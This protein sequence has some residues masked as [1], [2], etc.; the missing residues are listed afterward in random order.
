MKTEFLWGVAGIL[1]LWSL[2]CSGTSSTNNY[3]CGVVSA[4]GGDV[5]GS[6][7]VNGACTNPYDPVT[8]GDWCS[9]LTIDGNGLRLAMLGHDV[10]AFKSASATFN[11]ADNSYE[12]QVA[13]AGASHKEFPTACLTGFG[14]E[15]T[16]T[17]LADKLTMYL[18]DTSAATQA[19]F[20]TPLQLLPQYP[21]GLAPK[22]SYSNFKCVDSANRDRCECT[23][24]VGLSVLD[25]G[26][27]STSSGQL[28]LFS[29][30]EALPYVADYCVS[31][32]QMQMTGHAGTDLL[33]QTG[34]RALTFKKN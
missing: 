31:G 29:S 2:G 1:S 19:F 30:T 23:Y 17:D 34:L 8:S 14:Q 21:P 11:A 20:L 10:L 3:G 28:S 13:F 22:P 32:A 16:C 4:C 18:S 7:T 12:T 15:P 27:F 6:W 9:Q 25:K 33:G 24:A 5:D 26:V